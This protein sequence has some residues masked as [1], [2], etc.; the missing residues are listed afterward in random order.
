MWIVKWIFTAVM[1]LLVLGFAL[2]NQSHTVSL[3]L[4]PGRYETEFVPVW[5][6]VY[7]SF[8]VGVLFWLMVSIFQVIKLK[9][10][11]RHFRKDNE[12]LRM[13]LEGLRSNLANEKK[14][15]AVE[16]GPVKAPVELKVTTEETPL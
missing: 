13:E 6:V 15:S 7:A 10:E 11:I 5:L 8:G 12:R 1:I 3:T 9:S 4:I 14:I 2:Q 16:D